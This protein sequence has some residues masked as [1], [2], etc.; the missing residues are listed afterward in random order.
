MGFFRLF[1][2]N[3]LLNCFV[4]ETNL[5]ADQWKRNNADELIKKSCQVHQWVPATKDGN[6]K[7]IGMTLLINGTD[8]KTMHWLVMVSG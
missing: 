7:F 3:D 5:Y 2:D 8:M 6:L 4:I 1:V